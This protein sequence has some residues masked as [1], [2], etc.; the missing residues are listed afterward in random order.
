MS[1][2]TT[3]KFIYKAISIL[4]CFSFLATVSACNTSSKTLKIGTGGE[5]GTYYSYMTN[6]ANLAKDDLIKLFA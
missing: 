6:L 2:I 3:R 5:K 1:K 4:A